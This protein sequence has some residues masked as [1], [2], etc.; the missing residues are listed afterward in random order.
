MLL[1]QF[2]CAA[3]QKV[4]LPEVVGDNPKSAELIQAVNDNAAKIK[5]IYAP[6]A[7]VGFNNLPNYAACQFVFESPNRFRLR[8][9]VSLVGQ[10][11]D[12]GCNGDDF[13]FW[14]RYQNPD[15]LYYCKLN[16]C[17]GGALSDY[18]PVDPSWFPE[19]LGVD[20]IKESDILD[21]PQQQEDGTLLVTLK[22]TRPDG[23]Y[24]KRIYFEPRT[25]A[26]SRQDVQ[27]PN[28]NVV[29]SVVCRE[30]QYVE[31]PGVVLP[32]RLEI[33]CAGSGETLI[34]NLGDVT[35]NEENTIS[36]TAF[37]RPTD[38]KAREVDVGAAMKKKDALSLTKPAAVTPPAEVARK[39]DTTQA[40][41]KT[42]AVESSVVAPV[43]K[44]TDE[45]GATWTTVSPSPSSRTSNVPE[46]VATPSAN[47]NVASPNVATNFSQTNAATASSDVTQTVAQTPPASQ[48]PFVLEGSGV[49]L[50]ASNGAYRTAQA[51][52]GPNGGVMIAT[53]STSTDSGVA[54]F[55]A[56]LTQTTSTQAIT[57]NDRLT[58]TPLITESLQT[59]TPYVER[60]P[61]NPV[62]NQSATN[63]IANEPQAVYVADA[64]AQ[65]DV[66]IGTPTA[67]APN[68]APLYE[69]PELLDDEFPAF[70]N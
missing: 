45:S 7:S 5:S 3:S 32:K 25:A 68:A 44:Q 59:S 64:S 65:N 9:S 26:V 35:L 39:T 33:S 58:S 42:R 16:E 15:E 49:P 40:V 43:E 8:G 62:A 69:E 50:D 51:N 47:P 27:D 14:G 66:P 17:S 53:P 21:E 10:V 29:V 23:T 19:A 6:S 36:S 12:C 67:N 4:K 37:Q 38:L 24:R 1:L 31:S 18:M 70:S 34:F 22:K 28:G 20:E 55:P 54:P 13:W 2:G 56:N 60:A 61:Q 48:R 57:T 63:A 30:Q 52:A 46:V 11:V 41:E